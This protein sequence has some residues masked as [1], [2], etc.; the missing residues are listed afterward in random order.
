LAGVS[1]DL[2]R[3]IRALL[4]TAESLAEGG[5]EEAAG[6]YIAKAHAL[7]QKHSIDLALLEQETGVKQGA[8]VSRTW[9]IP[10]PYGRRK[11]DLA[12]A[13]AR[14]TGCTGYFETNAADG[15]YRFVV[16][17]FPADVEWAETLTF[18]LC[19][20]A[21]AALRVARPQ[22]AS[23]EHG[24]SFATSFLAGFTATVDQ[25]LKAAAEEAAAVAEQEA[26]T[27]SSVALVLAG[28]DDRVKA[29]MRAS[30]PRLRT[31]HT[32]G[33]RSASGYNQGRHA[34]RA[35]HLARGSIHHGR[36]RAGLGR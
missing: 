18:S 26:A 13:V 1:D 10:N 34:G 28:K 25:R 19:H 14:R 33:G 24:R 7:Q 27:G 29:E 15:Q 4:A 3:K 16:F 2:I 21:E 17:G 23:W 20:Q 35:A 12:H 11:I 22:K 32:D 36:P 6:A 5:N 31:V 8:V 9:V 30:A